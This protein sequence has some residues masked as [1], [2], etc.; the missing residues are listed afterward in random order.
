M[1]CNNDTVQVGTTQLVLSAFHGETKLSKVESNIYDAL[2]AQLTGAF[3]PFAA[4]PYVSTLLDLSASD[5]TGFTMFD[6]LATYY[7]LESATYD[8]LSAYQSGA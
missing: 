1:F 4:T 3:D 7:G 8:L 6:V 2:S 5:D